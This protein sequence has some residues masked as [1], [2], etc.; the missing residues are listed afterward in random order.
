MGKRGPKAKASD[1]E[2]VNHLLNG[3]TNLEVATTLGVS[4]SKVKLV[5][6]QHMKP[7]QNLPSVELLKAVVRLEIT[8]ENTLSE[9]S[10]QMAEYTKQYDEANDPREKHAWSQNRIKIIDMMAKIT[11]LYDKPMERTDK[12]ITITIN[13]IRPTNP[14]ISKA[15]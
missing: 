5:K 4:E 1:A 13:H 8:Q 15:R 2:I 7:N 14:D 9:L 11:G 12:D 10:T 3:L 6:A